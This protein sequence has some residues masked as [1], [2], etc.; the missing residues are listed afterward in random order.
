MDVDD[1]IPSRPTQFNSPFLVRLP[2]TPG[3]AKGGRL[4]WLRLV[5]THPP[6]HTQTRPLTRSHSHS[7]FTLTPTRPP[8]LS[9]YEC[10]SLS[11]SHWRRSL[12]TK[13]S[14]DRR[15]AI[16]AP[17]EKHTHT[18]RTTGTRNNFHCRRKKKFPPNPLLGL[19]T[20]NVCMCSSS[21]HPAPFSPFQINKRRKKETIKGCS[22]STQTP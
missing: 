5:H 10:W 12:A 16:A 13:Y 4:T 6:T 14:T 2:K 19:P 17:T 8:T 20:L 9:V 22:F 7:R 3:R 18:P 11:L 1:F 15:V 21:T